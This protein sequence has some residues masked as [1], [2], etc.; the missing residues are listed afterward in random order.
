M[1]KILIFKY[2]VTALFQTIDK[3]FDRFHQTVLGQ[4]QYGLTPYAYEIVY[5]EWARHIISKYKFDDNETPILENGDKND[6]LE[7]VY[8]TMAKEGISLSSIDRNQLEKLISDQYDRMFELLRFGNNHDHFK[9]MIRCLG[10]V[11]RD[12]KHDLEN[13]LESFL[14]DQEAQ[15][16]VIK[17]IFSKRTFSELKIDKTN[18]IIPP[19]IVEKKQNPQAYYEKRERNFLK[20]EIARIF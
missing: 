2:Q 16:R 8:A 9:F 19:H 14:N 17:L 1:H 13:N 15:D 11:A 12:K 18:F 3:W 4:K 20:Q 5:A 10:D 7:S 6:I